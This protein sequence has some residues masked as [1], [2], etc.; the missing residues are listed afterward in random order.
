MKQTLRSVLDAALSTGGDFA[1]IFLEDNRTHTLQYLSGHAEML[2]S[3]RAHGAGVRVFHGFNAVY[4]YTNDTDPE[5]LLR[6]ARQAG[7]W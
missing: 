6:C 3:N 2:N 4:A 1:E 5:G 7:R